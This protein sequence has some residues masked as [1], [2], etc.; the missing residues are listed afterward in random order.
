MTSAIT[1]LSTLTLLL[2]LL[3]SQSNEAFQAVSSSIQ[4]HQLRSTTFSTQLYSSIDLK[5]LPGTTAPFKN[6]FDPLR[7]SGTPSDRILAWYQAAYVAL[8]HLN[9]YVVLIF[10]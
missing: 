5:R 8:P 9:G 6:G 10:L 3:L 2:T 1:F 7:F 4:P